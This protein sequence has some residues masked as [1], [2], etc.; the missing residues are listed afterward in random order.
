MRNM[1]HISNGANLPFS[2]V[3]LLSGIART[4]WSW[5]PLMADI[6]NDGMR[7]LL[8]TNGFPR[9]VTD[10]D[11]SNYRLQNGQYARVDMILD[12][13]PVVKIPNYA[14]RNLGNLQFEDVG[15]S[16]GLNIASFSNGAV[17][18]DLDLDGDL[19]YIV[20]NKRDAA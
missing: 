19:D 11:F 16:W 15:E 8:I 17:Y 3:G 5:S 7:D 4:D 2:E 12:S 10:M 6:D 13:V 14:Y 18:S 9:D 1:L 20:N